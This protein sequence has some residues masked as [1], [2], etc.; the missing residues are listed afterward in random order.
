MSILPRALFLSL[1]LIVALATASSA[2]PPWGRGGQDHGPGSLLEE[3]ADQL[4]L[5]E[6]TRDA[7][8]D[9]VRESSQSNEEL[10]D[11][12]RGLHRQMKE[13]LSQDDPDESAVM[14]LADRIGLLETSLHKHRLAAMLEIRA[15]LTPEQ[16]EQLAELR[17]EARG[18]HLEPLADACQDEVEGLCSAAEGRFERMRCM[19][20]HRDEFSDA[21]REAFQDRRRDRPPKRWGGGR[22]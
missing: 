10:R 17:Q 7:I 18:R 20:E 11:E 9:V 15:A 5:D 19:R 13:L 21:C 16:R 1:L 12:L 22:Y 2:R 3:H 4:G 14:M 6:E 8:R